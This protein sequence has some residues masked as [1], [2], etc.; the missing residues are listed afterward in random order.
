[1]RDD[2]VTGQI[3]PGSPMPLYHQL[4][5]LLRHK[6]LS[7]SL[8]TGARLPS[9]DSLATHFEISR[10]TAKRSLNDLAHE[11]LVTRTRGRGT[12][13]VYTPP[14][15]IRDDGMAGLLDTLIT[16]AGTTDVQ[17]LSLAY[18]PASDAIAA[19]L[20]VA[21]GTV[22]QRAERL[23]SKANTP[24]S[25]MTT[26]VPED[27]GR[28]FNAQ[29]LARKPI[30]HL[31]ERAGVRIQQAQQT[32]TASAALPNVARALQVPVGAPL[33]C[34]GRRVVDDT[35]RVVQVID[36]LYRPDMYQLDMNLRRGA[37]T[38]HT[39]WFELDET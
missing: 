4:Y 18:E 8:A 16:I 9:E 11:G 1:M 36:V 20:G 3:D 2:G 28:T 15:T 39:T 25:F 23:R 10:I 31:I 27:I 13:V 29:D 26:H 17:V 12:V 7:G 24:F 14:E 32:I 19:R 30:L 35:G 22:V 21:P 5:L 37:G 34:V 38:N 6:I 33:L